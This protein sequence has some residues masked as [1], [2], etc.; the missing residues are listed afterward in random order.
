MDAMD[1]QAR[2]VRS[3]RRALASL[4]TGAASATL[5][6]CSWPPEPATRPARAPARVAFWSYGGTGAVGPIMEKVALEYQRRV[7]TTTIDF[8]GLPSAEIQDK[9]VVAMTAGAGPDIY[10]DSWRAFQRFMD[11]GWFLDITQEF[12]KRRY[13]P[14][15]FY[16]VPLKAHQLDGRQMGMPQGWGTSLF[17]I[18][19]DLFEQHGVTLTPG[20]DETWTQ[21]DCVRLLKQIVR[22]DDDGKMAPHG[23]ADDPIFFHWLYSYGADFLT[24]DMSRAAVTTPEALAA[25]EWY[26]RVHTGER[27]FMR[28]GIDK[29]A[30]IG[31]NL[32]NVAI[33]G[34]GIPVDLPRWAQF[35]FRVNVFLRPRVPGA[36]AGGGHVAR[37][38]MDSYLLFKHTRVRD[39][40]VDFL[41]WLL[42]DGA[43][44]IEREHGGINIP[45]YKKVAEEIFLK[46]PSPF[47]RKKWIE[48]AAQSRTD[49]KH[50]RWQ[51]DLNQIYGRYTAQLRTGQAA[52]REAMHNM[53]GEINAVLDEY[54]RQRAR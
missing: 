5:A 32:G 7:P 42:D 27:V 40:T 30:G 44:L 34:S 17:G 47:N 14:T 51:P 39:A 6:R 23:G 26:A 46:V 22:Y 13:R 2:V 36:R 15:D 16:D 43:V 38:Y 31:F 1:G 25:A 50:P 21:D 9:L 18:N 53:A 37:M 24:P 48:A 10:Y 28:D 52:P 8:T 11:N 19:L 35:P 33:N 45:P 54:R 3:R 49:P 4:A 29:R 41:F 12:G 20:F